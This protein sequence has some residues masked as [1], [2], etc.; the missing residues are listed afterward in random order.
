MTSLYRWGYAR[1]HNTAMTILHDPDK[2]KALR[3][4]IAR[5]EGQLRGI[6]RLI[7]EDADCEKVAQQM[8]AARKALDKSFFTLV[9]CMIEQGELSPSEI[10]DVLV[11]FA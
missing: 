3:H 2:K 9:A 6:Q 1:T 11:K 10:T 8:A 4:R 5:V 7:D